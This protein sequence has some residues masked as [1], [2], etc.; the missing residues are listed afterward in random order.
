LLILPGF[1]LPPFEFGQANPGREVSPRLECFRV[2]N[3]GDKGSG[4]PECG[5]PEL[6][7]STSEEAS[8][9]VNDQ[10]EHD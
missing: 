10:S 4:E 6:K 1:G 2:G 3:A 8:E 9:E 7:E 5:K